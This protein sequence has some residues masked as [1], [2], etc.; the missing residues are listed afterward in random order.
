MIY[1]LVAFIGSFLGYFIA[2]FTRE[3]LKSGEKYF[4][5]LEILILIVL[6]VSFLHYSFNWILFVF[7]LIFGAFFRK[8]YFYFGFGVFSNFNNINFL[9][10]G[11]IFI[12]GLPYGSLLFYR[13][14]FFDLFYNLA[15]F[16]LPVVVYY[17]GYN[18]LSFAGGGLLIIFIFKIFGF[19]R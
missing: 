18:M 4:K 3:E 7:G 8:E 13:K 16:F 1:T 19:F 11:L 17:L 15:W 5:I 14:K 2:N 10:S 12:Y 9:A 6:S